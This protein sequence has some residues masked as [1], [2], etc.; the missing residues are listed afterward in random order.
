MAAGVAAMSWLAWAA[1]SSPLV[2]VLVPA[3]LVVAYCF[4][5]YRL[6]RLGSFRGAMAAEFAMLGVVALCAMWLMGAVI[7]LVVWGGP[8]GPSN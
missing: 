6:I 8:I 7:A 3:V 5:I 2:V 4:E 1:S